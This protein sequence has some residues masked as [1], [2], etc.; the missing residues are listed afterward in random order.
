MNDVTTTV[1]PGTNVRTYLIHTDGACRGNP[2]P[3]A[4]ACVLRLMEGATILKEAEYSGG[5]L[6]TTNNRMEL[7]AVIR[8]LGKLKDKDTP[9]TVRSDSQYVTLGA[10]EWLPSWKSNG[11]RTGDRKPVKNRELWEELD[12][13]ATR[14][15][16]I[17]WEWVRGHD[18]DELNE[19]CDRLANQAIDRIFKKNPL[20]KAGGNRLYSYSSST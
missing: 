1:A 14:F 13:I 3:G 19:R 10:T 2:G 15:A 11:W 20:N 18:G 17:T 7:T 8:A 12:T 16:S 4:W 5:E 6:Q 9:V